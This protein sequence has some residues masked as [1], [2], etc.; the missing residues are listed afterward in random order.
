MVNVAD[1]AI[2]SLDVIKVYQLTGAPWFVMDELQEATIANAQEKEDITGKGGRKLGSLKKNKGVTVSGT[3]GLISAGMLEA[4]TGNT[5][6]HNEAAPVA[7]TDYLEVKA[8]GAETEFKAVGTAGAEIEGLY[9]RNADGSAGEKLEQAAAAAD[10]KFAYDPETKKLTFAEGALADGT[11]IVV[12][13]TRNVEADVLSNVSDTYSKTVRMYI[14]GTA[15]DKCG[16]VFHVQFYIPKADLNGEFDIQLGDSQATHA[17]EAE[18]VA[19][20]GCGG[21]GTK[22]VLWTYTVFGVN[23]EDAAAA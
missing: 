3:S 1:L 4:Q 7:W 20:A 11:E 16:N 2:T 14:D 23:T 21:V 9:M 12:F 22:G 19:G 15:E 17:F 6:V 13:Y 5:F 10:K 18:S 8:N